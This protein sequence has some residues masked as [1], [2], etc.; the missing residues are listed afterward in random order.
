[1]DGEMEMSTNSVLYSA[2]DGGEHSSV[3]WADGL[4]HGVILFLMMFFN[5]QSFLA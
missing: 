3:G 1:M 5:L 4:S 2:G